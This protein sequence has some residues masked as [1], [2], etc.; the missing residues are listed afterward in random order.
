MSF[1][2]DAISS[3]KE[4]NHLFGN[5]LLEYHAEATVRRT[6]ISESFE[7]GWPFPAER[8]WSE[9]MPGWHQSKNRPLDKLECARCISV[10]PAMGVLAL[11]VG[12]LA[13][14]SSSIAQNNP[15][16]TYPRDPPSPFQEKGGGFGKSLGEGLWTPQSHT[17]YIE[18][19][20][21][22]RQV[23]AER[24]YRVVV[25]DPDRAEFS[26]MA[27]YSLLLL[28]VLTQTAEELPLQ[29]VYVRLPDREIPLLKIS[30]WRVNVDQGLIT[31]R[32]YGPYR[33]D[34]FY[35][36]PAAMQL[37]TAQIQ[38][39]FAANRSGFPVLEFPTQEVPGWLKKFESSDSEP[40]ALP[41]LKVLQ[42]F[43]KNRTSGFPIPDSLPLLSEATKP[44]PE[45]LPQAAAAPNKSSREG[46]FKK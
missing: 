35:L 15:Q 19:R 30:S 16:A 17:Q 23:P 12:A 9:A 5:V 11:L 41:T 33:E 3:C 37:R 14:A 31:Y 7:T 22:E 8:Y 25:W 10:A 28:S 34:G 39:D 44:I 46:L 4:E 40:H 36:F 6:R 42:R 45:S 20:A 29:R 32:M 2:L 21:K 18:V 27:G 24:T 38:A 13:V 1:F 26:A 43:I